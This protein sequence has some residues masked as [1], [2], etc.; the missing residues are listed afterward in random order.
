MTNTLI[1][2]LFWHL[3]T[4]LREIEDR[5]HEL[6]GGVPVGTDRDEH[7][8]RRARCARSRVPRSPTCAAS[9]SVCGYVSGFPEARCLRTRGTT[10]A[11]CT[12][13]SP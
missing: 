6:E 4:R 9:R 10:L 1:V 2:V 11:R 8:A 5:L 12:V 3:H 7:P 13:T